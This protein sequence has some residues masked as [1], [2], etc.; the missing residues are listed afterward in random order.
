MNVDEYLVWAGEQSGRY[1]L[2]DGAVVAMSPEG[3]GH[4]EKK[5]PSMPRCSQEFGRV[6]WHVTPCR[7]A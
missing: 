1:E 5:P 3:A 4:A 2:L 7:T 6:A